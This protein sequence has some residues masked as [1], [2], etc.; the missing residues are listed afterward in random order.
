ML[1][2]PG[3]TG[4]TT[5]LPGLKPGEIPKFS[6]ARGVRLKPFY[7]LLCRLYG[8]AMVDCDM[9]TDE[10]HERAK[11]LQKEV[12]LTETERRFLRDVKVALAELRPEVFGNDD[13][14][15]NSDTEDGPPR[16]TR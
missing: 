10:Q 12:P 11:K 2:I 4:R 16:K 5:T 15:T 6:I 13:S 3:G 1:R 9:L 14:S 7:C 8:H